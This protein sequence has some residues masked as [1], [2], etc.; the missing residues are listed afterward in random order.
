MQ[1]HRFSIFDPAGRP[2]AA[3][4]LATAVAATLAAS[5][6]RALAQQGVQGAEIIPA[7]ASR[8]QSK[9]S[10]LP[11]G[12]QQAVPLAVFGDWNVFTNGAQGRDKLCYVIAQPTTRSPKTLARDTGYL[13]VTFPKGGAQGEIAVMLGFKPKPAAAQGKPGAAAA[14]SDPYLTVGNTRYGLV[15]KDEN[16]WIQNQA[17]EPR[18]VTEM[19]RTQTATIRTVSQRGKPTQD[20]YALGGFA[21]ALK[22]AREEC[23]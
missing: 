17:D 7:R 15:V 5:P 9:S 23:K 12:M 3:L 11:P 2:L 10:A 18:I 4:V 16:A 1:R 20:D 21:E 14:P 8:R 6:G 19:S 13:F 22:R